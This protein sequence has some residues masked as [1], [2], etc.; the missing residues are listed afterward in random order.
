MS[1]SLLSSSS[2]AAA[3]TTTTTVAASYAGF[4]DCSNN[5]VVLNIVLLDRTSTVTMFAF[6][7]AIVLW[8]TIVVV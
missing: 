2:A 7:N 4:C 3:T 8:Y 6:A 5:T 1:L